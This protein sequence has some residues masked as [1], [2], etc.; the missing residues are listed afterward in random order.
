MKEREFPVGWDEERVKRV[1]LRYDQQL[2]KEAIAADD[3]AFGES[4][5]ALVTMQHNLLPTAS[6]PIAKY[7]DKEHRRNN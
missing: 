2:E 5:Q 6:E 4:T 7:G 1:V 3:A